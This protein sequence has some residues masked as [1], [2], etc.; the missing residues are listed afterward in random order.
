MHALAR[1]Q[2]IG[3]YAGFGQA[4]GWLTGPTVASNVVV[5]GFE[6]EVKYRSVDHEV[7]ERRLAELEIGRA[8]C[9]ERVLLWV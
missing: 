9:R 6:V 7:L 8:S 4:P 1:S 3:A 5:M 2:E